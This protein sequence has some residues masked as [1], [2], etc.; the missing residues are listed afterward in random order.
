M[1]PVPGRGHTVG[2]ASWY[3]QATQHSQGCPANRALYPESA[4]RPE[5]SPLSQAVC[6][7]PGSLRKPLSGMTA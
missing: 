3:P 1:Q 7:P 6:L 2:L 5:D 4:R